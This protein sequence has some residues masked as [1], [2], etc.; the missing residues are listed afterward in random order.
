MVWVSLSPPRAIDTTRLRDCP[1]TLASMLALPRSTM[2]VFGGLLG[3]IAAKTAL[4]PKSPPPP[5]PPTPEEPPEEPPTEDEEAPPAS[6]PPAGA[7]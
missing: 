1:L 6:T 2:M 7:A 5:P 4:K 3:D